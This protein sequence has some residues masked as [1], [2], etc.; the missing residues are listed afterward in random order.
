MKITE[1]YITEKIE[2]YH[3]AIEALRSDASDSELKLTKEL[4]YNLRTQLADRLE[5]ELGKWV[6]KAKKEVK[7]T[8]TTT[9][10]DK[11]E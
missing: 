6:E 3:V 1:K 2:A 8:T 7:E 11:S 5:R 10:L 4:H 9:T